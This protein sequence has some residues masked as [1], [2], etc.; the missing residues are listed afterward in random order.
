MSISEKIKNLRVTNNFTQEYVANELD[1]SQSTYS[2]LESGRSKLTID[3]A[4]KL[5]ELYKVDPSI[6]FSKNTIHLNAGKGSIS[7]SGTINIENFSTSLNDTHCTENLCS[8]LRSSLNEVD[9][10]TIE[11][12]E[13]INDLAE[14][15]K[16]LYFRTNDEKPKD[17]AGNIVLQTLF[18]N[19]KVTT[20]EVSK[21]TEIPI[22]VVQGLLD[23][24]E[25]LKLEHAEKLGKYFKVDGEIFF[26]ENIHTIHINHAHGAISSSGFIRAEAN[27]HLGY[28]NQDER[29][30]SRL[31]KENEELKAELARL[32]K[33]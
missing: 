22:D 9:E 18:E 1:I 7:N 33:A 6:F 28:I 31:E 32:K 25:R 5:G 16:I 27:S 11:I 14:L 10:R 21:E 24:T 12:L 30:I 17:M 2:S 29:L 15:I 3:R 8:M 4:E 20:E 26:K 23:G 19:Y 13:K